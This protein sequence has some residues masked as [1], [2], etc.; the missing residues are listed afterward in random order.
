MP[1]TFLPLSGAEGWQISNPPILAMTPLIASLEIFERARLTRLWEKS[2]Q[3]TQFLSHG[4][5][6]HLRDQVSILTPGAYTNNLQP[7][8]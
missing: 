6:T 1:D 3:L 7:Q 8:A 4:I 2:L 5:E